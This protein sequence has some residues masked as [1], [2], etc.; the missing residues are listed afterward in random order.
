MKTNAKETNAELLADFTNFDKMLIGLGGDLMQIGERRTG[1][2]LP[3][4][5]MTAH[6]I[7][8]DRDRCLAAGMDGYVSKPIEIRA[9]LA[10]IEDAVP[11]SESPVPAD[12]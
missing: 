12:G 1:K 3:I 11:A 6:G 8:G 5:A 7:E 2:H 4:I 9:L 10:A